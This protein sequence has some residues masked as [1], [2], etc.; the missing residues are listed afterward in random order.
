MEMN[1]MGCWYE[2][3]SY[4]YITYGKFD[5][6]KKFYSIWIKIKNQLFI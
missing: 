2:T 1:L 5:A 4:N 6:Y 3:R